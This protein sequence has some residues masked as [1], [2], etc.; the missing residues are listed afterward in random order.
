M[1]TTI[2]TGATAGLGEHAARQILAEPDSRVII[3]ARGPRSGPDGTEALPLDLNSLA[4][5][6]TFADA[7]KTR[8]AGSPIDMLVLNAGLQ[9]P[10][11]EHRS[12][13][14][15]ESTFAVNHLAHYL[16]ARLLL[17]YVAERGRLVITTRYA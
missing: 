5:V 11:A 13:D 4:S 6:R 15:F 8:L 12:A 7:V 2:M 1:I 9:Y 10:K 17:P 3:G 16:L 14:G